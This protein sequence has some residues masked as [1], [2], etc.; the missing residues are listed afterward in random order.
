MCAPVN[1]GGWVKYVD[2]R[3]QIMSMS[4]I[5]LDLV[6][7]HLVVTPDIMLTLILPEKRIRQMLTHYDVQPASSLTLVDPHRVQ[8]Y[9][10]SQSGCSL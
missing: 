6:I 7:Q 4:N 3:C 2:L 5:L 9:A 1:G 10:V 8:L